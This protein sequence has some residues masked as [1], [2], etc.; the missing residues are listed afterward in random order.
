MLLKNWVTSYWWRRI[1]NGN[2]GF[3]MQMRSHWLL[4]GLKKT[5]LKTCSDSYS[6]LS[7]P[8]E[9]YQTFLSTTDF[10]QKKRLSTSRHASK[11][12]FHVAIYSCSY[13][14]Q[15]KS[16]TMGK[17]LGERRSKASTFTHLQIFKKNWQYQ[18]QIYQDA[19][20]E[21]EGGCMKVSKEIA[22]SWKN[23]NTVLWRSAS[24]S[25]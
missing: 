17:A 22:R 25:L 8:Y 4:W 2:W 15:T 10:K 12:Q 6:D 18:Y 23:K 9:H 7:I 3:Q 13:C 20:T 5:G 24:N 1:K 14:K 19:Q 11:K 21:E 16:S